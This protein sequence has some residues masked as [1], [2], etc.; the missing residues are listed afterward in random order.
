MLI[1]RLGKVAFG[2][3]RP[4]VK[5]VG[6]TLRGSLPCGGEAVDR[7]SERRPEADHT[8]VVNGIEV[9]A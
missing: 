9:L 5:R 3:G 4:A 8:V 7:R 6:V 1:L 2:S